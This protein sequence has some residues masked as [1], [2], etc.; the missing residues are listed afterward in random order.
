MNLPPNLPPRWGWWLLAI[1]S[2]AWLLWMTLHPDNSLNQVNLIPLAEHGR[3]LACLLAGS[4][5]R[6]HAFWF[7]LIDVIGNIMVFVPLGV[8]LAG[9]LYRSNPWPTIRR[10]AL[11]GFLFSL[12]IELSQ[13]AIPSRATDVDDLIFNTLGATLGTLGLVALKGQQAVK[14]E[15]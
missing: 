5:A 7:L 10:V 15:Q 13:L 11:L 2:M 9:I 3:A 12:A 1:A 8:G 4:C 14:N 6:R